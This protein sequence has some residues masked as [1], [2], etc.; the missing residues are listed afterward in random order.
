MRSTNR[1]QRLFAIDPWGQD[2]MVLQ[3]G[4]AGD[5]PMSMGMSEVQL[6]VHSGELLQPTTEI[7]KHHEDF[8]TDNSAREGVTG[9]LDLQDMTHK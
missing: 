9:Q 4:E 8:L 7:C 3:S 6:P 1:E 2:V 5:F